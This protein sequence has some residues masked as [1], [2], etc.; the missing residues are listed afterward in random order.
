M[1]TALADISGTP[2]ERPASSLDINPCDFLTSTT[3]KHE[4]QGQ[5]FSTNTDMK[6]FTATTLCKT[7]GNGLL[8]MS[9]RRMGH[10][11][12]YKVCEGHYC[13]KQTVLRHQES[14]VSNVGSLFT[15]QTLSYCLRIR[16][17]STT[18]L[19]LPIA[20]VYSVVLHPL[21]LTNNGHLF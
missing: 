18:Q 3:L 11:K 8:H 9:E 1:T 15:F 13:E 12:K 16:L 14:S 10:C 4:L 5:K 20:T 6:K 7:P 2:V 21:A 19:L 17:P